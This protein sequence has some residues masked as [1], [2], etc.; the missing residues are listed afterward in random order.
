MKTKSKSWL[1]GLIAFLVVLASAWVAAAQTTSRPATRPTTRGSMEAY[2]QEQLRMQEMMIAQRIA[3]ATQAESQIPQIRSLLATNPKQAVDR[4]NG[5]I[6]SSLI[7]AR[8]FDEVEEFAVAGIIA[9]ARDT[10]KVEQL[11]RQRVA[12]FRSAGKKKEALG[13]ARGLWNVAGLG[14][15]QHDVRLLAEVLRIADGGIGGA[16]A[17]LFKLQQLAGAQLDEAA[18]EKGMEGLGKSILLS[19]EVD[20]TPFDKAIQARSGAS[21]YDALYT[22]GNLLL[23]AGRVPEAKLTFDKAYAVAPGGEANYITEG[24][25]KVMKAED[26]CIGRAN[27]FVADVYQK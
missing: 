14:S 15:V 26:G 23:V 19:I 25:A 11:Q 12:A 6:L 8:R 20:S 5:G 22:L 4:L 2:Q 1:L 18:R 10:W 16:Q 27:V 17:N 7:N 13:A 21:D 3:A 9:S 24:T